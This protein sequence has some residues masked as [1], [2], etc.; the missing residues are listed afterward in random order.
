MEDATINTDGNT[1]QQVADGQCPFV[2]TTDDLMI[3][4]TKLYINNLNKERLLSSCASKIKIAE[5][6]VLKTQAAQLVSQNE[7]IK[8]KESNSL[9]DI[10]NKKLDEALTI[11]RK[12]IQELKTENKVQVEELKT[13]NKVQV[14]KNIKLFK[15]LQELKAKNI[16]SEIKV[17]VKKLKKCGIIT[18]SKKTNKA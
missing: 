14:E 11:T 5:D 8:V 17:P 6:F 13:E 16:K 18:N 2:L 7:L 10:N 15:E 4:L 3:E 9:F 1:L 12:E